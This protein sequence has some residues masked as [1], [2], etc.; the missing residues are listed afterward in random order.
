[1]SGGGQLAFLGSNLGRLLGLIGRT[2]SSVPPREVKASEIK[3]SVR[4]KRASKQAGKHARAP[5]ENPMSPQRLCRAIS[6]NHQVDG[7]YY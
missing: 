7:S 3:L 5:N 1:M 4:N 2:R 6:H